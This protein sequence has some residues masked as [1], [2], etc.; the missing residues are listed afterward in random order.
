M[1]SIVFH[2]RNPVKDFRT[3]CGG[4]GTVLYIIHVY[5]VRR[6]FAYESLSKKNRT[7][8]GDWVGTIS[9]AL[10]VRSRLRAIEC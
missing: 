6:S 2:L 3:L 4:V 8:D 1:P 5:I 10:A 9:M 7:R